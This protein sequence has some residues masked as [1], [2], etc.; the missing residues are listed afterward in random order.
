MHAVAAPRCLCS[1]PHVADL[2]GLVSS[3]VEYTP[4]FRGPIGLALAEVLSM[5][6]DIGPLIA[7]LSL[8]LP[9]WA[10]AGRLLLGRVGGT[11]CGGVL[12]YMAN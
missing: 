7:R 11:F 10:N 5:E 3:T 9:A 1:V 2:L 4:F 6:P 8:Q 12:S